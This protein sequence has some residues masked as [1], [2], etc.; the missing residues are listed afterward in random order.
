MQLLLAGFCRLVTTR[1]LLPALRHQLAIRSLCGPLR[2]SL[3]RGGALARRYS[4]AIGS[5]MPH[6]E[7]AHTRAEGF[8]VFWR[9]ANRGGGSWINQ[10]TPTLAN[11]LRGLPD[12]FAKSSPRELLMAHEKSLTT[13]I[14]VAF[15]CIFKSAVEPDYF[16]YSSRSWF[17]VYRRL[18]RSLVREC[19][20][21]PSSGVRS[22]AMDSNRKGRE[23]LSLRMEISNRL[24]LGAKQ[25]FSPKQALE[26]QPKAC[27]SGSASQQPPDENLQKVSTCVS[28]AIFPI[29]APFPPQ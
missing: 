21:L 25:T 22:R 9:S 17:L 12:I 10:D 13:I 28:C 24:A 20:Q 16:H 3:S 26:H 11:D 8:Q 1:Q 14:Q 27:N 29:R 2:W 6:S 4:S 23:M 5:Q 18:G 15:S 7:A 19:N